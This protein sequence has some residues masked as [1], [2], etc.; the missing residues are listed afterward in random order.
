MWEAAVD[1]FLEENCLTFEDQEESPFEHFKIHKVPAADQEFIALCEDLLEKC[2]ME[3][4]IDKLQFAKAVA[5]GVNNPE[6]S[7]YFETLYTLDDFNLFKKRMIRK[8]AQLNFEAI[9]E[10]E[11]QGFKYPSLTRSGVAAP[12]QS[13]DYLA[14]E[15]SDLEYALLIS[16]Q[17]LQENKKQEEDEDQELMEALRLSELSYKVEIERQKAREEQKATV[18]IQAPKAQPSKPPQATMEEKVDHPLLRQLEKEKEIQAQVRQA[19]PSASLAD[20]SKLGALP[21][22]NMKAGFGFKKMPEL[23]SLQKRREEIAKELEEAKQNE[24][25]AA[26]DERKKRILEQREK[27]QEQKRQEREQQLQKYEEI[28]TEK[29]QNQEI[30]VTDGEKSKRKQ[31]YDMLRS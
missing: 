20:S 9:Q 28:K 13:I 25:K 22:L 8:N 17:V 16:Q 27:M 10:L 19:A 21:A 4:G 24:G 26:L 6:Y 15:K 3:I 29:E 31:I 18:T 12:E 11:K 14:K 5:V 7:E 30:T 23:E 2:I 1:T